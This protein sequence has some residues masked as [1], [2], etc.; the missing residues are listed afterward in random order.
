MNTNDMDAMVKIIAWTCKN[1]G[2][3]VEK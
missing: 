3:E 1:M 2:V